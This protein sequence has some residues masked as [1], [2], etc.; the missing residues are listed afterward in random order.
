MFLPKSSANYECITECCWGILNPLPQRWLASPN[1]LFGLITAC[2]CVP[3]LRI[4]LAAAEALGRRGAHVV[5]SSR[6][7]AN[8]DRA[9]ATLQGQDI[10]VTG[11]TCNVG[12]SQDREKLVQMASSPFFWKRPSQV[13]FHKWGC[14]HIVQCDVCGS[15]FPPAQHLVFLNWHVMTHDI[16]LTTDEIGPLSFRCVNWSVSYFR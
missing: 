1:W 11:T 6:R 16:G 4:G 9:V 12:K 13:A 15:N 8:V 10:K 2:L 14:P 3:A 7:Q 5:V